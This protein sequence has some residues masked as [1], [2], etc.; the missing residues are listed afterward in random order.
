[1]SHAEELFLEA[2]EIKSFDLEHRKT[3]LHNISQ[4]DKKVVEGERA[5]FE[6]RIGEDQ[7]CRIETKVH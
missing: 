3:I 1:M 4:Y 7:S 2:S 6:F 5:V